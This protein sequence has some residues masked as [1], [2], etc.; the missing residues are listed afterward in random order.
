MNAE[1]ASGGTA[2]P[3]ALQRF[4]DAQRDVHA[5]ALAE[6]RA[7]RKRGHWIWY[8]LPQLRGLGRSALS[9]EYGIAG[10]AEATAYLAHPLLGPRL[11]ECVQALLEHADRPAASMLGELDALKLQSCLTLFASVSAPDSLFQRALDGFFGGA[12][13]PATLRLLRARQA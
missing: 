5:Q 12:G 7:G 2:S 3:Q 8:V 6:L 1:A 9:Q 11:H 13:D 4:V 10:A